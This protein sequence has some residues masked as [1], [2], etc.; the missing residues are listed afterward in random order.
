MHLYV[1]IYLSE[2]PSRTECAEGRHPAKTERDSE[3]EKERE[4]MVKGI[5]EHTIIDTVSPSP[6]EKLLPGSS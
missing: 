3:R 2:S 5:K 1:C 6:P 4:G